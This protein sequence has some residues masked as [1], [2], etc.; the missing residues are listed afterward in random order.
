M[1][2]TFELFGLTIHWYGVILTSAMIIAL[3]LFVWLAKKNKVESDFCLSMFLF[4][5]IFAIVG[6]RLFYVVP[7]SEY[8]SSWEGFLMAFNISQG[9]LTIVGAIPIGAIGIGICCYIYKKSPARILD[10]VVPAMLLGQVIGRW[11][12]FV[13][14]E[15]YGIPMTVEWLQ[16]F[17][18]SVMINGQWHCASF[19]YEMMLNFFALCV[20]VL[21][22]LKMGDKLKP[23]FMS[24]CYIIWYGLVRGILEFVKEDPLMWGNVRAIQMICFIAAFAGIIVLILLQTGKIK[25]ETERMRLKHFNIALE[26][27]PYNDGDAKE[28]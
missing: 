22:I 15:L 24:V 3:C 13:N 27:P 9:G 20:S 7:R 1:N 10:L 21:L 16:F 25:F 28:V 12:N 5:I 26:P 4:A 8:W 11:G 6:A 14:Q 17:P 18:M 23:G 19:F 2:N